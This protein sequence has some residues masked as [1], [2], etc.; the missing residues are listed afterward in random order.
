MGFNSGFNGG[1]SGGGAAPAG[2]PG[3]FVTLV[4][5]SIAGVTRPAD[6]PAAIGALTAPSGSSG[7]FISLL[8]HNIQ[9]T[10]ATN[11][12]IALDPYRN[13]CTTSS[14]SSST[15][16]QVSIPTTGSVAPVVRIIGSGLISGSTPCIQTWITSGAF[17]LS[18]SLA[19]Q[20]GVAGGIAIQGPDPVIT[21]WTVSFLPSG[22]FGMLSVDS[23]TDPVTWYSSALGWI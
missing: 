13:T 12:R 10:S 2:L 11:V 20:D 5:S 1:A 18:G 15:L 9:A 16:L 14:G 17:R 7:D 4:S 21:N 3:D 22:S 8:G 23:G 19:V 6:V